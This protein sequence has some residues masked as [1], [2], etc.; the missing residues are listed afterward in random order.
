MHRD[1]SG[2]FPNAGPGRVPGY[3]EHRRVPIESQMENRAAVRVAVGLALA[4]FVA[5]ALLLALDCN[6]PEILVLPAITLPGIATGS[7]VFLSLPDR[8]FLRFPVALA[9]AVGGMVAAV[10]IDLIV[11][12]WSCGLG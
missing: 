3:G 11:G 7:A 10:V 5:S 2:D 12:I 1:R 6:G 9:A 4:M 8:R